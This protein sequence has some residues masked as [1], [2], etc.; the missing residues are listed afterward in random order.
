MAMDRGLKARWVAALRGGEYEQGP[1]CLYRPETNKYCC[2]G[3]LCKVIDKPVGVN[4]GWIDGPFYAP[5]VEAIGRDA[6]YT[7][8]HLNDRNSQTFAQIA[9]YIDANL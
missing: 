9:D 1:F 8:S 5:V 3:I 6:T 4:E 2:L 7:L